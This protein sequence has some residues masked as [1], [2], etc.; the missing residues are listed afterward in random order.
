MS[1]KKFL[2][3]EVYQKLKAKGIL[4]RHFEKPRIADFNRITIGTREEMETLIE[5]IREIIRE[6]QP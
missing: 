3:R 6:V 4:I 5:K 2:Y 1:G